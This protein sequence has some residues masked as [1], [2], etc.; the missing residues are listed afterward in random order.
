MQLAA[1][2]LVQTEKVKV[3]TVPDPI[4]G[5]RG[6]VDG[7]SSRK[8]QNLNT[9]HQ[10]HVGHLG[11]LLLDVVIFCGLLEVLGFCYLV[12]KSQD[13]PACAST[14]VPVEDKDHPPITSPLQGVLSFCVS[15]DSFG[16]LR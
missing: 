10:G 9:E 8:L 13:F 4:G 1:N 12:H 5:G 14:C 7:Q 3:S 11:Y 16:S 6:D 2:I 15:C